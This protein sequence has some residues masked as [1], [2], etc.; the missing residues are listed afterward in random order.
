MS[1]TCEA[2]SAGNGTLIRLRGITRV[3]GQ[4]QAALHALRGVDLDVAAG[5]FVAVMGPSGSGKS[6]VMNILGCLDTPTAG[7]YIFRGIHVERLGRD[8][9]AELRRKFIGFV[10]QGFNL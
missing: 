2:G 8:Q 6:T 3:Y 10:F 9:R 4:G 7:E 1:D 5:D